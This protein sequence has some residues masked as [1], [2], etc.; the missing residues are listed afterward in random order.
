M[1]TSF[2]YQEDSEEELQPVCDVGECKNCDADNEC[3]C[4]RKIDTEEV[5]EEEVKEEEVKEEEVKEE[6]VK[7]EES[8]KSFNIVEHLLSFFVK[9]LG[10]SNTRADVI[11]PSNN[12]FEVET[13]QAMEPIVEKNVI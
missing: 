3:I 5:K 11:E 4:N 1:Y 12:P 8:N 6:E 13:S 7:E 2:D 9:Y 10:C